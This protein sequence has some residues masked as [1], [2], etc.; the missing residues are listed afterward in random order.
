MLRLYTVSKSGYKWVLAIVGVILAPVVVAVA[1]E[2]NKLVQ[3]TALGILHRH[4]A[5]GT[6]TL[7][8]ALCTLHWHLALCTCTLHLALILAL[9]LTLQHAAPSNWGVVVSLNTPHNFADSPWRNC[10]SKWFWRC[11][12]GIGVNPSRK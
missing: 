10:I 7:L 9:T 2:T 5:R 6:C 3:H 4:L 12:P 8:F 1:V 11:V